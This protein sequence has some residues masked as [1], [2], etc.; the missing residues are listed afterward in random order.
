MSTHEMFS[1]GTRCVLIVLTFVCVGYL[2]RAAQLNGPV[3]RALRNMFIGL[4]FT[5]VWLF[6][7]FM[8]RNHMCFFDTCVVSSGAG[9]SISDM[10]WIPHL[11]SIGATFQ[12]LWAVY[13][14]THPKTPIDKS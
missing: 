12:F 4:I 5:G 2:V 13:R 14:I 11:F 3:T 10:V 9:E 8:G 1:L 7:G 6:F